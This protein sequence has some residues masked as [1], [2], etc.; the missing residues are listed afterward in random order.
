M[1]NIRKK[2]WGAAQVG[3]DCFNYL[4]WL[5]SCR[6]CGKNSVE[7]D[8]VM[9][10]KCRQKF[11]ATVADDYCP[12]CGIAASKYAVINGKCGS[13]EAAELVFDGIARI[14]KYTDVL[15]DLILQIKHNQE[16]KIIDLLSDCLLA[17][18][19]GNLPVEEIDFFAP[20]PLHWRRRIYRGYNQS[21]LLLNSFKKDGLLTANLLKRNRYTL[22]QPGLSFAQKRKNIK[23]A[24]D[25]KNL[26]N[27]KGKTICLIDDIK[28]TGA[29]LGECSRVLKQSG[30][31]KVYAAV[32]AVAGD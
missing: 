8:G 30:A 28:T 4:L 16:P 24:F 22:P 17:A 26:K 15:R 25:C 10:G 6:V 23:G 1:Q 29:T 5:P 3:S 9:C 19:K 20:V 12:Y 13:C 2:L 18:V 31:K 32:V 11:T 7:T 27:I 21:A 14:G